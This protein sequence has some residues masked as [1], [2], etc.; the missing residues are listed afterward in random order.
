M[1]A[2]S[3][4]GSCPGTGFASKRQNLTRSVCFI[5]GHT[6]SKGAYE[7][8]L[9]LSKRPRGSDRNRVGVEFSDRARETAHRAGRAP[10]RRVEL[11]AP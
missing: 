11:V 7:S 4:A 1:S 10:N 2:E 9:D 5:V 3:G 6:D 8:N